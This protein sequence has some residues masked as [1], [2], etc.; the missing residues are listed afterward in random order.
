MDNC[1]A[2]DFKGQLTN[3][4]LTAVCQ[5]RN[6]SFGGRVEVADYPDLEV[7]KV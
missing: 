6:L 1:G 2:L 5:G 7:Q 3:F 4:I